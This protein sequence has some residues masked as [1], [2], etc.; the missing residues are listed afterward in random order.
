M[1]LQIRIIRHCGFWTLFRCLRTCV[2]RESD[3]CLEGLATAARTQ[4]L[5][6]LVT[7]SASCLRRKSGTGKTLFFFFFPATCQI[8]CHLSLETWPMPS[9]HGSTCSVEQQTAPFGKPKVAKHSKPP[10]EDRFSDDRNHIFKVLQM[11]DGWFLFFFEWFDVKSV[12]TWS[13]STFWAKV[14]IVPKEKKHRNLGIMEQMDCLPKW[15]QNFHRHVSS[16]QK[17][18]IWYSRKKLVSCHPIAEAKLHAISLAGHLFYHQSL[19][20]DAQDIHTS[21]VQRI[22]LS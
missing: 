22:L 18:E 19:W 21:Y 2:R 16:A 17:S 15:Q 13:K 10:G 14:E 8:L 5:A 7:E 6:R 11:Y 20:P 9:A 1:F 3:L 12:S 4:T